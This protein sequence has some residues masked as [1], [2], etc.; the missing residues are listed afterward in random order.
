MKYILLTILAVGTWM[1]L[2]DTVR[3]LVEQYVLD[4]RGR[5]RTAKIKKALRVVG[6]KLHAAFGVIAIIIIILLAARLLT[7]WYRIR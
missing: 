6:R 3:R 1:A 7:A 4:D 5:E 2:R